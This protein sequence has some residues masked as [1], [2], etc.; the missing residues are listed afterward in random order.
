[1]IIQKGCSERASVT[2]LLSFFH[3]F[4]CGPFWAVAV[5]NAIKTNRLKVMILLM[6]YNE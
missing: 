5:M 6:M 3:T 4:N 2:V 1:M